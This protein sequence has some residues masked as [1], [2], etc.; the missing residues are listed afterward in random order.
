LSDDLIGS[1][2]PATITWCNYSGLTHSSGH[3][4]F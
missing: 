4:A 2:L 1:S 3:F